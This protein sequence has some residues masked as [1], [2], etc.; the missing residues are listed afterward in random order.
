MQHAAKAGAAGHPNCLPVWQ[1]QQAAAFNQWHHEDC[2]RRRRRR[3][4]LLPAIYLRWFVRGAEP[5]E[6]RGIS[7]WAQIDA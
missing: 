1:L 3:R 6:E 7:R 5:A 2:R 4:R